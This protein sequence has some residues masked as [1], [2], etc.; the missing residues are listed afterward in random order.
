MKKRI[1]TAL[2]AV[3]MLMV[4]TACVK[5][6]PTAF[7]IGD[8]KLALQTTITKVYKQGLV[9]RNKDG[10]ERMDL[11]K[12]AGKHLR[13][14]EYELAFPATAE[15]GDQV[16]RTGV[17]IQ[18]YNPLNSEFDLKECSAY[19]VIWRMKDAN[20][21]DYTATP[22]TLAGIN[23]R[24]MTLAD[25]EAALKKVRYEPNTELSTDT[26]KIFDSGSF[27]ISVT[28]AG[29]EITVVSAKYVMNVVDAPAADAATAPPADAK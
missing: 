28:L 22:I 29:E 23:F 26:T 18:A 16:I 1:A 24:G 7:T 20:G 19:S 2:L 21:A 8:A 11:P 3:L 14:D 25:A 5:V 17:S 15:T 4:C 10:T 12:Y 6:E 27:R 9:I 13:Y